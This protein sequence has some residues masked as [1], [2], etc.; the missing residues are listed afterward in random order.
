MG[1]MQCNRLGCGVILCKR[2]SPKYGYICDECFE[3][4]VQMDISPAEFMNLPKKT[5]QEHLDRRREE[6]EQIF[7]LQEHML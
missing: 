1:V 7:E 3:E 2:Y 5:T 4:L 6:L